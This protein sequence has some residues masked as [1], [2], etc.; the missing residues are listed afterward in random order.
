MTTQTTNLS[1]VFVLGQ[2][3]VHYAFVD[4]D[5]T[6]CGATFDADDVR[7]MVRS[8]DKSN[9]CRSCESQPGCVG[10]GLPVRGEMVTVISKSTGSRAMAHKACADG[11]TCCYTQVPVSCNAE[12]IWND[13]TDGIKAAAEAR[14]R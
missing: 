3:K 2:Y 5:R 10:C 12:A 14:T 6:F 1:T 8:I 13:D 4:S 7:E 11:D 9:A